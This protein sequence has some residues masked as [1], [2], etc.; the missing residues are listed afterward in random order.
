MVFTRTLHASADGYV[1]TMGS[2]VAAMKEVKEVKQ[3]AKADPPLAHSIGLFAEPFCLALCTL[4]VCF[5]A[6]SR[7]CLR[8][9]FEQ[10]CSC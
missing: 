5:L 4:R 7:I 2:P 6:R 10:L 1:E 9:D 3:G 8:E